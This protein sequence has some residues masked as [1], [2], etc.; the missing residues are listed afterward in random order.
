M[1]L[2]RRAVNPH[3]VEYQQTA[4]DNH[5]PKMA[6]ALRDQLSHPLLR[7]FYDRLARLIL[8]S[9]SPRPEPI[10]MLEAACG[11][12]LLASAVQRVARERGQAIAYTGT[13]IS[14]AWLELARRV[15]EGEF[16]QGEAVELLRTLPAGSENVIWAKNL[17][18]HLDDPA[19]FLREAMRVVGPDG[20]V[21]IVEPRMWCPMH[22]VNLLWFRTERYQFQGYRRTAAAFEAAGCRMVS[23][24]AFGWLPY[25]L[26][27]ATRLATPRRLLSMSS[28]RSLDRVSAIDD[29]LTARLPDLALYMVTVVAAR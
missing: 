2:G 14:T 7:S 17:L 29:R 1:Q 22:W 5:Y 16:V 25:E 6:A 8:D 26:I 27:L 21:V 11:E 4:Y 13:D 18:H 24:Q 23:T 10:S 9:V 15:I 20:R 19:A 12:G 3:Q 28:R